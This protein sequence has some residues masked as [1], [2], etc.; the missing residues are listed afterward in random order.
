MREDY[1]VR[2]R[3][4]DSAGVGESETGGGCVPAARGLSLRRR[5]DNW[6]LMVVEEEM[7]VAC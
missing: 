5:S 2:W 6:S 7:Q 3:A 1:S 4:M